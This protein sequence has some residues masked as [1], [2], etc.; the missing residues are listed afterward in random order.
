VFVSA[1]QSLRMN[2]FFPGTDFSD[3]RVEVIANIALRSREIAPALK[4]KITGEPWR[5][6]SSPA[7]QESADDRTGTL[8]GSS[9]RR[10]LSPNASR[11]PIW[12]THRRCRDRTGRP[13]SRQAGGLARV[14][15]ITSSPVTVLMS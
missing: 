9:R 7:K 11:Q 3:D 2:C 4:S 6:R 5:G 15:T 10:I 12:R 13:A 1:I 8:L 14:T